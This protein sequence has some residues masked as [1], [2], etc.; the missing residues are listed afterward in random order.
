MSVGPATE[1]EEGVPQN[2]RVSYLVAEWQPRGEESPVNILC[3]TEAAQSLL[4]KGAMKLVDSTALRTSA[5]LKVLGG[6]VCLHP[7]A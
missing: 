5:L 7:A 3:H 1:G 4:V 6:G 2:R